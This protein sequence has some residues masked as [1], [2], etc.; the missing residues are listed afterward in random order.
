MSTEIT[1]TPLEAALVK[2]L[3]RLEDA[4][5]AASDHSLHCGCKMCEVRSECGAHGNS[6]FDSLGA[7]VGFVEE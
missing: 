6:E 3:M 7:K 1:L 5:Y 4:V 2:D